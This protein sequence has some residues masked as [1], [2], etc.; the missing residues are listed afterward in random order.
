V[1]TIAP[2]KEQ[3]EIA[4]RRPRSTII[5]GE[6]S[7]VA[8]KAG[9]A[10]GLLE[11]DPRPGHPTLVVP[12]RA[13]ENA[14]RL[15]SDVADTSLQRAR[16]FAKS[17][18]AWTQA[19]FGCLAA[20]RLEEAREAFLKAIEIA[21][22]LR[23]A[24]LGLAR[25]HFELGNSSR[26]EQTLRALL[27]THPGDTEII[28]SL[29]V[30]LSGENRLESALALLNTAKPTDASEAS[31]YAMRGAV[32]VALGEFAAAIGDLRKAIRR[33]PDWVHARNALGI[34]ELKCGHLRNAERHFMEAMRIAPLY[35]ESYVNLL[36]LMLAERRFSDILESASRQ[37]DA[38]TAPAAIARIVGA[39]ALELGQW[40]TSRLWLESALLKTNERQ[41][42]SRL[43]NDLGCADSRLGMYGAAGGYFERSVAEMPNELAIVNRAKAFLLAHAPTLAIM[44]LRGAPLVDADPSVERRKVLAN[45]YSDAEMFVEAVVEAS[46][47]VEEGLADVDVFG[48]V[49]TVLVDRLSDYRRAIAMG[50]LAIER[51]PNESLM[52]NNL[53]YSLL[54]SG[55]TA[56]AKVLLDRAQKLKLENM[57]LTATR[58]LLALRQGYIGVGRELYEKALGMAGTEAM[59]ER[60]RAKRDLEV[61]RALLASGNGER[62]A[63]SLLER[64][65]KAGSAASPYEEHARQEMRRLQSGNA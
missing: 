10:I 55:E 24:Q 9:V 42:R 14:A 45:A 18:A 13:D 52:I 57:Y 65:S 41:L 20:E 28:V 4:P 3:V 37:Y 63:L 36:R 23:S 12:L 27:D 26:A 19:G 8:P 49:T 51:F 25:A 17:S 33:R 38:D 22:N 39:S 56:R 1:S 34:A 61:A 35:E 30:V 48:L 62:E 31:F 6:E 44:W 16:L 2:K 64:A 29:A 5:L 21:P 43:L 50:E 58:G 47:L 32:Q 46:S 54:M 53:A 59:R 15:M 60:V 7:V 11:D 40:K